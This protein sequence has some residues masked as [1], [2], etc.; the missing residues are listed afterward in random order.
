M[1]TKFEYLLDSGHSLT[2]WSNHFEKLLLM[3]DFHSSLL[4]IKVSSSS[5]YSPV[6]SMTWSMYV[7]G[8]L[9]VLFFLFVGIQKSKLCTI[10]SSFLHMC[11]EH[12]T[13][14]SV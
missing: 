4:A 6:S 10:S 12:L 5:I 1:E 3:N 9:S 8:G 11:P 2:H 14:D 13:D 7:F